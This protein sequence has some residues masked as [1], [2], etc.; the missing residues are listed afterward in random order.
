MQYGHARV[1]EQILQC[2]LCCRAIRACIHGGVPTPE[3]Q[4]CILRHINDNVD[5]LFVCTPACRRGFKDLTVDAAS[6]QPLAL[7]RHCTVVLPR[8]EV[9]LVSTAL[10]RFHVFWAPVSQHQPAYA[11]HGVYLHGEG[12]MHGTVLHCNVWQ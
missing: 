7:Y 8:S 10:Q 6:L 12:T 1:T 9:V 3:L 5:A 11:L 4:A 2:W